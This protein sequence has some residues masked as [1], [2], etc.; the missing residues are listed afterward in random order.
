MSA[1][2]VIAALLRWS[3]PLPDAH[4]FPGDHGRSCS[5]SGSRSWRSRCCSTSCRSRSSPPRCREGGARA[6]SARETTRRLRPELG[7]SSRP[8][9]PG[10]DRSQASRRSR[11]HQRSSAP[12]VP[13]RLRGAPQVAGAPA[14]FWACPPAPTRSAR[15]RTHTQRPPPRRPQPRRPQPRRPQP[16]RPQARRPQPRRPQPRRLR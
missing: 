3:P 16:R 9:P 5:R 13:A 7:R 6:I 8:P 12:A 1:S 10:S 11:H 2:L 14:V 15:Q 4:P